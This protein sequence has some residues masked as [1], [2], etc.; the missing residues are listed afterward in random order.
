MAVLLY[1]CFYFN[2]WYFSYNNN[3]KKM[4]KLNTEFKK[5]YYENHNYT[6]AQNE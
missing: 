4:F 1:Y 3:K 2:L 5:N 6:K